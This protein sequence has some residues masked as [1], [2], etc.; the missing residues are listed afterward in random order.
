MNKLV[1]HCLLDK[2]Q[3]AISIGSAGSWDDDETSLS[4]CAPI[5]MIIGRNDLYHYRHALAFYDHLKSLHANA[6][7]IQF[8]GRHELPER[9]L[10]NELSRF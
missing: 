6:K 9:I 8:D 1:Q 3:W 7:L 2:T 4:S 5:T 10:K